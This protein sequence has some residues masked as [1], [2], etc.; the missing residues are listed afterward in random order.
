MPYVGVASYPKNIPDPPV[1]MII[2]GVSRPIFSLGLSGKFE[3]LPT[4][5]T[6]KSPILLIFLFSSLTKKGFALEIRTNVCYNIYTG[7]AK[8]SI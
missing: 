5:I 2:Y 7:K 8:G 6:F 1:L 4:L 3:S